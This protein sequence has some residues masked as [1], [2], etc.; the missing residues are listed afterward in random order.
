[1]ASS[2][3]RKRKLEEYEMQLF[4][5]HSRA[6]YATMKN[7]ISE[8]VYS[9][10]EKLCETIEKTYKLNSEKVKV[11]KAN[12][13]RLERAYCQGALPHLSTIETAINK[14]IAVP[15][16][17]LLDEDKYQRIQ[18]SDVEFATMKDRLEELQQRAKRATILNA[19]LKEELQTLEKLPISQDSLNEMNTVIESGLKCSNIDDKMYQLVKD[20]KE[21]ST[22]VFGTTSNTDKTKYNTVDNLMCKDIDLASL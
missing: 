20:Y 11:L 22:N 5:F 7:I 4:S 3:S 6:V 18:Y 17:V 2:E 9:T 14:Y 13:K 10:I 8:R 15:S 21:F 12:Q 1:M 19:A 16:N